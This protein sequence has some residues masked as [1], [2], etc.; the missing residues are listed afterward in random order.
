MMPALYRLFLNAKSTNLN[1][2][3]E[4]ELWIDQS[5]QSYMYLEVSK[6]LVPKA[7]QHLEV[8][9]IAA[10]QPQI[11][12]LIIGLGTNLR[13]SFLIKSQVMFLLPVVKPHFVSY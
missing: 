11:F 7:I 1:T 6:S 3:N 5:I 10:A 12:Y 9:K 8:I 13:I 2:S 4:M